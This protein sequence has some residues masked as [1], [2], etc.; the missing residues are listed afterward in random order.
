M[1]ALR[2]II[3]QPV[4]FAFAAS[5]LVSP[6]GAI[7]Q[8]NQCERPKKGVF[9]G[10][11]GALKIRDVAASEHLGDKWTTCE[12]ESGSHGTAGYGVAVFYS[13][14]ARAYWN[15]ELGIYLETLEKRL[16]SR[17]FSSIAAAQ[18][19]W[20]SQ[21]SMAIKRISKTYANKQGT[22]YMVSY[23]GAVMDIYRKR[24]LNLGCRLEQSSP[25]S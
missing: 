18:K 21:K 15:E 6:I 14:T 25:S 16:G 11:C 5:L 24:A 23:E 9:A 1:L 8:A 17:K 4:L 10:S 3:V 2:K 20:E 22:M 12:I 19:R 13:D 7:A